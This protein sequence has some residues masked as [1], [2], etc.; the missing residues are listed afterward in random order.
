MIVDRAHTEDIKKMAI[1]QGM[2]TL[3]GAGMVQVCNGMTS[4]EEV[5][6]V[7]V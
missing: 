6:R 1:A 3:R 2:I 4:V 7:I 5:L